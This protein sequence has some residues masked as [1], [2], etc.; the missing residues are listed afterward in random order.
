MRISVRS[1]KFIKFIILVAFLYSLPV[2]PEM[3]QYLDESVTYKSP[4]YTS[5]EPQNAPVAIV[6]KKVVQSTKSVVKPQNKKALKGSKFIQPPSNIKVVIDEKAKK[7]GVDANL[8]KAI[9]FCESD[10]RADAVNKNGNKSK[11]GGVAQINDM[12]L[13]ELKKLG[14]DRFDVEDGYEFMSILLKRNGTSDYKA[15]KDCWQ[16]AVTLAQK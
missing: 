11:D 15:S 8:M 16:V 14:L 12:H 6:Q 7:H 2:L 4:V 13:P 3:Y 10:Y 5:P 1:L 9:S